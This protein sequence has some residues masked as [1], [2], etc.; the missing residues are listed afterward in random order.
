MPSGAKQPTIGFQYRYNAANQRT[1][2][3]LTDGSYWKYTYDTLGHVIAG[4]RYW[5]DGTPVSGQ[6]FEYGF[7]DIGNHTTTGGRASAVSNYT[8]GRLNRYGTGNAAGLVKAT[9]GNVSAR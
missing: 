6:Q 2:A 8:R 1:R 9:T 5:Q 4:R 3:S 7:D